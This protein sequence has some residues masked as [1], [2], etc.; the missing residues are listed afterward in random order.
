MNW[1]QRIRRL[2]APGPQVDDRFSETHRPR[3]LATRSSPAGPISKSGSAGAI[4]V[5]V[6]GSERSADALALADSLAG[7]LEAPLVLVHNH[8]REAAPQF[9][10]PRPD[11]QLMRSL[12]DSTSAQVEVLVRHDHELGILVTHAVSPAVG[13]LEMAERENAQLIVVGPSHR[14]GLGRVR[15]GSVGELLLSGAPV[16][17]AIAPRGH[18]DSEPSLGLVASAFDGSPESRLALDWAARLA[19]KNHSQLRVISVHTPMAFGGISAGGGF[20]A[21]SVDR[22]LR[23]DLKREQHAA[24]AAY[25]GPVECLMREGDP[26]RM[27]IEASLEANLLVMGSRGYRPLRAALLGGVSH[28]VV[29]HAACPV[30]IHP[31]SAVPKHEPKPWPTDRFSEQTAADRSADSQSE[32]VRAASA[33]RDG[34]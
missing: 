14:S 31:R 34:G 25:D 32:P 24:I 29:H 22:V 4:I 33:A 26:A 7:F 21:E 11:E 28:S 2:G 5:G 20:A 27:L 30:V 1:E 12:S 15:P 17:V 18:A 3:G 9:L 10:E 8:P 19:G 13:L 6:E 16:P 23:R